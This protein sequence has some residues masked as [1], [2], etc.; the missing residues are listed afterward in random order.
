MVKNMRIKELRI[1]N[2]IKQFVL[3]KDISVAQPTVSDW[4]SGKT[5]PSIDNLISLSKYF[6]VTVG[7]VVGTEPIPEGYPNSTQRP[8]QIQAVPDPAPAPVQ[9]PRTHF[10]PEAED[11]PGDPPFSAEQISFLDDR[12]DR[13]KDEIVSAI[14]EDISS[15]SEK[16]HG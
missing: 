3:A 6:N 2:G 12:L 8:A 13:L 4:E 10:P 7:C 5:N 14:Q 9:I 1:L 11:T 15:L 16:K